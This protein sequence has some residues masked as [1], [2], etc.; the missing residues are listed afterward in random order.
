MLQN[1]KDNGILYAR[2]IINNSTLP[3]DF[4]M[5]VGE[6]STKHAFGQVDKQG[7]MQGLGREVHDFLYEG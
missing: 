2:D 7:K 5:R 3:V 4:N 1:W 6:S